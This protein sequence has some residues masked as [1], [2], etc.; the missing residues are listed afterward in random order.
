MVSI[1]SFIIF[2]IFFTIVGLLS[3]IK[4]QNT[5]QD[6]LLASNNTSP[7]LLGLSAFATNNSGFMFTALIGYSYTV[8]LSAIWIT[9]PWIAGDLLASFFVMKKVHEKTINGK[10]LTYTDILTRNN[11]NNYKYLRI[12]AAI[13]IIIF[14]GVH[15]SAQFK[16]TDF[17]FSSI[18][19]WPMGIGAIITAIIVVLYCFVGGIRASIW[20]DFAQSI[21]M[22]LAMLIMFVVTINHIGGFGNFITKLNSVSPDYMSFFPES[23]IKFGIIGGIMVILGYIVGGVGVVGQPHIM[24]RYMAMKN[25]E[26]ITKVRVAYYGG[27]TLFAIIVFSVGFSTRVIFPE[28][29]LL[30][31]EFLLFDMA[32]QLL[33]QILIGVILAGLFASAVSTID[34]QVLSC[35]A[36]LINDFNLGKKNYFVNKIGT[37]FIVLLALIISMITSQSIFNLVFSAWS[38]LA[39][40]FAPIIIVTAVGGRLSEKTSIIM[41][42]SGLL[43]MYSWTYLGLA[44]ILYEVVPGILAGLLVYFITK[45]ISKKLA[46]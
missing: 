16:A 18:L 13:I 31:R 1:I 20:T 7:W 34:S 37:I 4:K 29:S 24:I 39:C 32:N 12:I 21:T 30:S 19:N 14:L 35:S 33:P 42:S 26:D 8:G 3:Y 41:M 40:A 10:Y 17:A 9:F 5:T 25:K 43:A 23:T 44:S 22:F 15:A 2:L 11:G 46:N 28:V 38:V 36:C 6:Y 27:Y 45:T